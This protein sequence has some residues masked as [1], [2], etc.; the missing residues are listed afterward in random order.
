M[1]F[2]EKFTFNSSPHPTVSLARDNTHSFNERVGGVLGSF[3][4]SL[5]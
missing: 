2:S 1:L 5:D 4:H 3:V